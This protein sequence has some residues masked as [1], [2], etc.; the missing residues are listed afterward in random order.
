MI[1]KKGPKQQKKVLHVVKI[2]VKSGL[3]PLLRRRCGSVIPLML[4]NHLVLINGMFG[5]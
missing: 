5:P 1:V 4:V 3:G 2:Q